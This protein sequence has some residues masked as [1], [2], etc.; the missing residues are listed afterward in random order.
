MIGYQSQALPQG[1]EVL[2]V[3]YQS[4][5]RQRGEQ[6]RLTDGGLAQV[7]VLVRD[8]IGSDCGSIYFYEGH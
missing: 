8:Q 2:L 3:A 6:V 1:E 7:T 4:N 5:A